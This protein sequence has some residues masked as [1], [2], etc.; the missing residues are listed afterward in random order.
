VVI[1]QVGGLALSVDIFRPANLPDPVA[2]T[3][4]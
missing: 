2:V 1:H 4:S 3:T